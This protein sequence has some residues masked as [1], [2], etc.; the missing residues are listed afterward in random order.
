MILGS[1]EKLAL[2]L[3][4]EPALHFP[5]INGWQLCDG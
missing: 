1:I 4:P 3:Y 2:K 5:Q